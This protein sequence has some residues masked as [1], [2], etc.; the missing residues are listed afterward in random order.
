MK[1]SDAKL[2]APVLE[3]YA[4]GAFVGRIRHWT[5]AEAL[6]IAPL[7]AAYGDGENIQSR[8]APS[9]HDYEKRWED[10]KNPSF[11]RSH[12]NYRVAPK[13]TYRPWKLTEVPLLRLV[14]RTDKP[15]FRGFTI[16]GCY[17]EGNGAHVLIAEDWYTAA[18]VLDH[19]CCE[20]GSPCGVEE[21]ETT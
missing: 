12:E 11:E 21:E 5:H 10:V 2:L 8:L 1:R 14:R 9:F 3:R 7:M 15:G 19:F 20:D 6:H 4:L 17:D 13:V 18:W 16:K